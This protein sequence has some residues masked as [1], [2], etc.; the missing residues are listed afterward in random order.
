M[1][2]L[3]P[4]AIGV[5]GL[6]AARRGADQEGPVSATRLLG[7][8]GITIA[9]GADN[10]SVYT[11]LF[12]T[13]GPADTALTIGVFLVLIAVWCAAGR[14]LGTRQKIIKALERVGHWLVPAVFIGIGVVIL[15]ESGVLLRLLAAV[16]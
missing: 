12:R 16:T 2:G 14:L 4:L 15:A 3:L 13:L 7:V 6:V 10:I 8:A 9:N 5:R 11:P 1:L